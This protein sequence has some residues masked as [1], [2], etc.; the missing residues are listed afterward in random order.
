MC[1]NSSAHSFHREGSTSPSLLKRGDAMTASELI[2]VLRSV[3][4]PTTVVLLDYNTW[5][6]HVA[7]ET[8]SEAWVDDI[9]TVTTVKLRGYQIS[10]EKGTKD[11]ILIKPS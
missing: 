6:S 9:G 7:D 1:R 8:I 3:P 11:A 4:G 10:P 5:A 2:E